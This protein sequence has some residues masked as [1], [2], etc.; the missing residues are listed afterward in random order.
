MRVGWRFCTSGACLADDMRLG[1]TIQALA[2]VQRNREAND[3]RID[4]MIQRKQDVA[5]SIVGTG[6]AWITELS[7]SALKKLFRLQKTALG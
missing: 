1:K 5:D 4:E 2:R 3:K 7:T 6:E